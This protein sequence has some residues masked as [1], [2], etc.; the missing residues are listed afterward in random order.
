L[1]AWVPRLCLLLCVV[2][3]AVG[4]FTDYRTRQIPNWL[5]F[6]GMVLGIV[7]QALMGQYQVED[8]QFGGQTALGGIS[9]ALLGAVV[10]GLPMW[11]LFYKQ[12]QREDGSFDNVSGGGDV[13]ILAAMGALLG[14]YHGLG[15]VFLCLV[16]TSVLAMARLAW[17]G[18]LLRVL[19]NVLFLPLNPILP[20]RWQRPITA[21]LL[22]KVRMGVPILVGTVMFAIHRLAW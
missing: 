21:E 19:S 14:L 8:Q 18:R 1:I 22:H 10:C 9:H 7:L 15:L 13:K 5:T 20:K 17:H 2:L 6:G 11:L 3:A 16:A 12:V 4:A